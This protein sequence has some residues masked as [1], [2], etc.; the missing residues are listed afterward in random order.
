[1]AN[2]HSMTA[3]QKLQQKLPLPL[4]PLAD[5]AY[6]YWWSWTNDRISLFRNIDPEA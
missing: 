3:A 2:D 6:N 1:M 4:K 5:I